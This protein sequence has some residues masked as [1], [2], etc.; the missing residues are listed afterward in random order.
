M[1]AGL[2]VDLHDP[3]QADALQVED[4]FGDVLADILD[5]RELV[6]D[7]VDPDPRD[8][9]AFERAQQ[10]AAQRVAQRGAISGLQWLDLVPAVVE[11]GLD[12]FNRE[13]AVSRTSGLASLI[14]IGRER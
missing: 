14:L 11:A 1:R 12:G 2:A 9:D 8:R 6:P 4:D 7:A 10:D 3:L 5:R 13:I